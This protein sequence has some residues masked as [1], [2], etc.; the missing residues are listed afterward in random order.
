MATFRLGRPIMAR[1]KAMVRCRQ[2]AQC[3]F[4]VHQVN[5]GR[6]ILA[7]VP[8]RDDAPEVEG[9]FA[10]GGVPGTAA[11]INLDFGDFAG[12]VVK[13]GLL[14]PGN[15]TDLIDV[16]GLGQTQMSIVDMANLHVFVRASD[17][18]LDTSQS[19]FDLQADTALVQRL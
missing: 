11:R 18:G 1:S 16:P 4:G 10:I 5:L 7:D 15:P 9:D 13:R 8:M 2:M 12:A 19:I 17:V 6:R 14:P 3:G